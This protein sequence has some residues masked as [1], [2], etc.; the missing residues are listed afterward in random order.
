MYII[1]IPKKIIVISF[2]LFTVIALMIYYK[3]SDV[4][5]RS[6]NNKQYN[7]LLACAKKVIKS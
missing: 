4:F 1:I 2:P 3:S 6:N 7:Q 5:N